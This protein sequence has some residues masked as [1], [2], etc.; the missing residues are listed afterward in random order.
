VRSP[1][2]TAVDPHN[3][4]CSGGLLTGPFNGPPDFNFVPPAERATT[5]MPQRAALGR[6]GKIITFVEI[7]AGCCLRIPAF[8]PL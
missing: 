7:G 1:A 5:I 3:A 6:K 2:G 8:Q 4:T